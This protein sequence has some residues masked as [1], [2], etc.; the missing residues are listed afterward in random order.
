[1]TPEQKEALKNALSNL[2]HTEEFKYLMTLTQELKNTGLDSPELEREIDDTLI[3]RGAWIYD[4]ING[5]PKRGKTLV[6]KIRKVLGYT[7]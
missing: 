1:M 6:Q 4:T 2:Y 7:Y 5:A 3:T